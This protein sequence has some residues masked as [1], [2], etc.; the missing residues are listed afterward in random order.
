MR[1]SVGRLFGADHFRFRLGLQFRLVNDSVACLLNRIVGIF[2]KGF[3]SFLR[4]FFSAGGLLA[5]SSEQV[6]TSLSP[7]KNLREPAEPSGAEPEFPSGLRR[8]LGILGSP[9]HGPR[10]PASSAVASQRS[11]PSCPRSPGRAFSWCH[12]DLASWR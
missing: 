11:K 2:H 10:L 3:V 12:R 7:R 4:I 9:S 6:P 1:N 8:F 5:A